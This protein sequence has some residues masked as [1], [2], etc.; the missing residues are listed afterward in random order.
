MWQQAKNPD[1]YHLDFKEWWKSDIDAMVL[2]DRNHPSVITAIRL[3][4][5]SQRFGFQ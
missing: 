4:T 2:R 3:K 1:D 5:E